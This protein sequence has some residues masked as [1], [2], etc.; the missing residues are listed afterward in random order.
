MPRPLAVRA[1][2]INPHALRVTV[3]PKLEVADPV[4]IS[5]AV[6]VVHCLAFIKNATEVLSHDKTML[7]NGTESCIRG[8]HLE[9]E[10]QALH[11][12]GGDPDVNVSLGVLVP[13]EAVGTVVTTTTLSTQTMA[14][15]ETN[16][17]TLQRLVSSGGVLGRRG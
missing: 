14:R 4:V 10:I 2:I 8:R 9:R 11:W 13:A 15:Q 6:D 3:R 7:K 5:S 12:Q 16:R 1:H 17:M